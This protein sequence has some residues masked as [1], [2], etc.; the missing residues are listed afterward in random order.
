MFLLHPFK[1]D[2]GHLPV[3][4]G[5]VRAFRKDRRTDR[6]GAIRSAPQPSVGRAYNHMFKIGKSYCLSG[7]PLRCLSRWLLARLLD[8][9]CRCRRGELISLR[10]VGSCSIVH[11]CYRLTCGAEGRDAGREGQGLQSC[12]HCK[13]TAKPKWHVILIVH[14][15]IAWHCYSWAMRVRVY[16][17]ISQIQSVFRKVNESDTS[18]QRNNFGFIDLWFSAATN[19]VTCTLLGTFA[20]WHARL[21][22]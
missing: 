9:R 13:C 5:I 7:C 22:N 21:L 10:G 19:M 20:I 17:L 12:M 4:F 18:S 1:S 14:R 11:T 2:T 6:Q 15:E 8:Q 16:T 3:S